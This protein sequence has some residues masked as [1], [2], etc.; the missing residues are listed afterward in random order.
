MNLQV[1]IQTKS[2]HHWQSSK[3]K[4]ICSKAQRFIMLMSTCPTIRL[5]TEQIQHANL[6]VGTLRGCKAWN[7]FA[8]AAKICEMQHHFSVSWRQEWKKQMITIQTWMFAPSITGS[9]ELRSS[10]QLMNNLKYGRG[11]K[12][13]FFSS[14]SFWMNL[15]VTARICHMPFIR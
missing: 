2:K 7:A 11:L 5:L 4:S 13:V 6:N 8:N 9:R 1:S 15:T 10:N 12:D 3:F 14:A